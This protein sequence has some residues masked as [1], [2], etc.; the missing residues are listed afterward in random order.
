MYNHSTHTNIMNTVKKII[1]ELSDAGPGTI[2]SVLG[3]TDSAGVTTS[4]I[5]VELLS[6]AGY[7]EIQKQDMS[8]LEGLDAAQLL[9]EE[10][11]TVNLS[12]TDLIAAR[13]SL[14]DSLHKS[15]SDRASGEPPS[16][17]AEYIGTGGSLYHLEGQDDVVYLQRLRRLTALP[18]PKPAKGAI[19]RAKQYIKRMLS[20]PSRRY[21]H[22]MKFVR[23]KFDSIEIMVKESVE[24]SASS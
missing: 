4:R 13:Q 20:L 9:A 12:T 7:A 14:L 16:R 18:T 17:G 8:L 23:G 10:G 11:M 19:P 6:R 21:V 1:E 24:V 2:L 15:F 5:E 3:Y 22:S